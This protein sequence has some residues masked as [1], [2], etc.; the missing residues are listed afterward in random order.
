MKLGQLQQEFT[1]RAKDLEFKVECLMSGNV[2]ADVAIVGELPTLRELDTT[3]P[4]V[5]SGGEVIWNNLRKVTDAYNTKNGTSIRLGRNHVYTTLVSKQ[6]V[7]LI[8]G[9]RTI[10]GKKLQQWKALLQWELAQLPNL[11]YIIVCGEYALQAITG[12]KSIGNWRGS[13]VDGEVLSTVDG[14]EYQKSVKVMCCHNPSYVAHVNMFEPIFRLDMNKFIKLY[15]DAFEPHHV[16]VSLINPTPD[17]AMNYCV[18]LI[19]EQLPV[20]YD[21]ETMGNETACI[22]LSND[23]HGGMCINFRGYD[24]H[25]WST[26]DERDVRRSIM[27][28]F[29]NSK[30][31]AQN[32]NF[33]S[34]WLWYKDAMRTKPAWFDTMLAHHLLFSTLPHGL[35]FLTTQYTNHPYYKDDGKSWREGG[36][37]NE[38]W[39]YNIRDV[40]ITKAVQERLLNEL[41][42]L[43]QDEFFFNHVMRL[44]PKLVRITVG[45]IMVDSVLKNDIAVTMRAEVDDLCKE[46]QGQVKDITKDADT[47]EPINPKSPTQLSQLFYGKLGLSSRYGDTGEKTRQKWIDDPRTHPDTARMLRTL[48][49]YKKEQKFSST[50]AEMAIDTDS[51]IRCEYKQTGVQSAPGRLSSAAVMWGTGANMQNQPERAYNMFV[52]DPDYCFVYFDLA[53]AEARVV[54]WLAGIESWIKQFEKARLEGGYDAHRALAADMFNIPYDDVPTYDRTEDGFTIRYT[55]KR[56]RHGLNY[57][58]KAPMLAETSGLSIYEASRAFDVYHRLTPELRVWWKSIE[59]EV[60]QTRKLVSPMGRVLRFLGRIDEN[61]LD[62]IVAFKPQSTIGDKVSQVIYE[63]EDD[64]AWPYDARICMNI[65]DALIALAPIKKATKVAR[66]MKRV[67][68]KPIMVNDMPLIIPADI[69]ISEAGD[70]GVHRWSTLK[71]VDLR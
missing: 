43:E 13:I 62:S 46:F 24:N 51:R 63:C 14:V 12:Q 69:K 8:K 25:R 10:D 70:D 56:C 2:N 32:G 23:A 57:R 60:Y 35:G 55:A 39:E 40:A 66:I 68:E 30:L 1:R 17:E 36:N 65:H 33:D 49:V 45:G 41:I 34:Y 67:A 16:D 11:K 42:N 5:G 27:Q 18:K 15:T 19:D 31:V 71:G 28:V 44:Q 47:A 4:M 54:A 6:T 61:S 48:Q 21:I 3:M 7:P 50:Y 53:Q 22:G 37:I 9:K 20:A 38:F 64:T 52:A 26:S 59:N 58:M 29:N